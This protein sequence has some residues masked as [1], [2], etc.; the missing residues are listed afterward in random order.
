MSFK[1]LNAILS[2]YLYKKYIIKKIEKNYIIKKN[3]KIEQRREQIRNNIKTKLQLY[4]EYKRI[5]EDYLYKIQ[6]QRD[7]INNYNKEL[8]K[9]KYIFS[10]FENDN[11][12]EDKFINTIDNTI[13]NKKCYN[14][15]NKLSKFKLQQFLK[16]NNINNINEIKNMSIHELKQNY[17]RY[18]NK[19]YYRLFIKNYNNIN[20][21]CDKT[22]L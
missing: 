3:I 20:E 6:Q 7:I 11:N 21:Q 10:M 2:E 16:N 17:N 14:V 15:V 12:Y 5:N 8:M 1:I 19:K 18:S 9:Y 22:I 13:V 4:Y